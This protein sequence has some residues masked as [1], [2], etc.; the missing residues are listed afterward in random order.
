MLRC[1]GRHI[2]FRVVTSTRRS[3]FVNEWR[4]HRRRHTPSSV[5]LDGSRSRA[6]LGGREDAVVAGEEEEATQRTLERLSRRPRTGFTEAQDEVLR[7]TLDALNSNDDTVDVLGDSGLVVAQGRRGYRTSVDS[8]ALAWR[9]ATASARKASDDASSTLVADLGAG[10]GVVGLAYALATRSSCVF[11]EKQSV[12]AKRCEWNA[13]VNGADGRLGNKS[14]VV[15]WD[16]A[17]AASDEHVGRFDVV[18][19]NPPYFVPTSG[20]PTMSSEE[21]LLA[22]FESTASTIDF[23]R[24]A[25]SLLKPGGQFFVVYPHQGRERVI[26]AVVEAFGHARVVDCLDNPLADAPSLVFVQATLG[27][28]ERRGVVEEEE[29]SPCSLH[30]E[31]RRDERKRPYVDEFARFLRVVAGA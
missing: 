16:V 28:I 1:C 22:R 5:R 19:C 29:E 3:L 20:T 2:A 25:A 8:L 10:C 17:D 31:P 6:K 13:R 7:R 26:E 21:K 30:P 14:R 12:S 4:T 15:E 18:L 9:A 23:A 24:F 27:E 11:F